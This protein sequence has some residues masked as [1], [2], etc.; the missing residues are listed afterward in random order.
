V[1]QQGRQQCH[2]AVGQHDQ[3]PPASHSVGEGGGSLEAE[4]G[5]QGGWV[6][7]GIH[8]RGGDGGLPSR[9]AMATVG[10]IA[11]RADDRLEKSNTRKDMYLRA[12]GFG[13]I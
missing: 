5:E 12:A 7:I 4:G 10:V 13:L 1:N 8:F 6:G 11:F 3:Q 9:R 2:Q